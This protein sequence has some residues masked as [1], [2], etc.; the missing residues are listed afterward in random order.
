MAK[1]HASLDFRPSTMEFSTRH[2]AL[3]NRVYLSGCSQFKQVETSQNQFLVHMT[4]RISMACHVTCALD[5]NKRA[6]VRPI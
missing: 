5:F 4:N 2:L 6:C 3:C 1:Y